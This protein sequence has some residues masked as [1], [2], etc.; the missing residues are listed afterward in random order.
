VRDRD[1]LG[2]Q[3]EA[4]ALLNMPSAKKMELAGTQTAQS[5]HGTFVYDQKTGRALLMADGLPATPADKAYELWFIPKVTRQWPEEYLRLTLRVM[6][7]F[8]N[9]CRLRQCKLSHRNYPRTE[10][11][12]GRSHRCDLSQQSQFLAL[13]PMV[14]FKYRVALGLRRAAAEFSPALSRPI[15]ANITYFIASATAETL[16]Q[17]SLTRRDSSCLCNPGLEKAG[18]NSAVAPRRT[19][20]C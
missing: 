4:L 15:S 7:C 10:K 9:K 14:P 12:I 8:R 1:V 19:R 3:R 6:R 13:N 17:S 11:R 16:T 5:A 2:R 20:T 18:L